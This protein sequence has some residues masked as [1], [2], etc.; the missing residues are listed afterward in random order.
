KQFFAG[1]FITFL[2]I[3]FAGTITAAAQDLT[4][5]QTEA[6]HNEL[7]A[8]HDRAVAAM[9]ARDPNA[10]MAEMTDDVAFTAMNNEVVHGK[11]AAMEYYNKMME[12]ASSIVQDMDV[13]VEPDVLSLLYAG[14]QAAVSTGDSTAHFKI[15]GGLEFTAPLRWTATLVHQVDGWKIASMHFSANIFDSPVEAGIAKYLWLIIAVAVFAGL[16]LGFLAGRMRR[17]R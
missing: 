10:L 15:R 12:G 3:F 17:A 14:G 2:M 7:R 9:K 1:I 5:Q 11:K 16:F 13:T 4:P 8:L 6:I